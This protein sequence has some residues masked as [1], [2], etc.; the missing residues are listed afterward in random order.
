MLILNPVTLSDGV[1]DEEGVLGHYDLTE[2]VQTGR[3]AIGTDIL[4]INVDVDRIWGLTG[5]ETAVLRLPSDDHSTLLWIDIHTAQVTAEVR[6]LHR[7]VEVDPEHGRILQPA[8]AGA[9]LETDQQGRE[10]RVLRDLPDNEWICFGENGI[11]D[12]STQAGGSM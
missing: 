2:S 7:D 10:L 1:V 5:G 12:A 8:R 11:L 6:G 9:L 4:S 3:P